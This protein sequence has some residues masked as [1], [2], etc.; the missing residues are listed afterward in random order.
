M[1]MC[2]ACEAHKDDEPC[3]PGCACWEFAVLF[4]QQDRTRFCHRAH[5]E[6]GYW[7]DPLTLRDFSMIGIAEAAQAQ[8]EQAQMQVGQMQQ[9]LQLQQQ[10]YTASVADRRFVMYNGQ[11]A[12][13]FDSP[14]NAKVVVLVPLSELR[15]RLP[16]ITTR[17]EVRKQ[18]RSARALR[19]LCAKFAH[20]L[21]LLCVL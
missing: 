13:V 3:G 18:S 12:P 4:D 21:L 9:Q 17:L 8:A 16:L 10:A 5:R 11:L 1:S 19:K 7:V 20:T 2:S 15:D 14:S 6:L